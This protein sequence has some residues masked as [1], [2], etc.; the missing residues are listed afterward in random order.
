MGRITDGDNGEH[1][2]KD[3]T[4]QEDFWKKN[5]CQGHQSLKESVNSIS[6]VRFG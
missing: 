2:A 3:I 1:N 5:M 4:I 6:V